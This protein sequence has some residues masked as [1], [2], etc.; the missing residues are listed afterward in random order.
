MSTNF[1]GHCLIKTHVRHDTLT[2]K[3][4]TKILKYFTI[5]AGP[6]IKIP[7]R[8]ILVYKFFAQIL[9][10]KRLLNV[11]SASILL[12]SSNRQIYGRD[13][14]QMRNKYTHTHTHTHTQ[15]EDPKGRDHL[16]DLDIYGRV[17]SDHGEIWYCGLPEL[18]SVYDGGPESIQPF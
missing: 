13:M 10:G 16:G 11:S 18:N 6:S 7:A 3:R 15:S 1:E 8:F 4:A 2:E 17:Y 5:S 14:V 12:P 9:V